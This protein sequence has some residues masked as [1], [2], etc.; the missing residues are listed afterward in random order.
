MILVE[1]GEPVVEVDRGGHV[2]GDDQI[3]FARVGQ[4]P[5]AG[6]ALVVAELDV[7]DLVGEDDEGDAKADEEEPWDEN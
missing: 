4:S 7:D 6:T 2:F 5:S 3:D 1:V